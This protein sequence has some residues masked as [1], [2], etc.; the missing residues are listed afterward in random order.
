MEISGR[1]KG[2]SEV[3]DHRPDTGIIAR[4][5]AAPA[6]KLSPLFGGFSSLP[7]SNFRIPNEPQHSPLR[8][9]TRKPGYRAK[10]DTETTPARGYAAVHEVYQSSPA[11][12]SAGTSAIPI[13]A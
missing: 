10:D 7:D 4:G 2:E 9:L 5:S 13:S 8:A 12:V 3:L 11:V 1:F 6:G